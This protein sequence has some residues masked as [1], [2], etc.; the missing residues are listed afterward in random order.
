MGREEERERERK[1]EREGG[2]ERGVK[3]ILIM[4][5]EFLKVMEVNEEVMRHDFEIF[6]PPG[7][8]G[9]AS[10]DQFNE[11]YSYMMDYDSGGSV[12]YIL[13]DEDVDPEETVLLRGVR[14]SKS[15]HNR[16][17]RRFYEGKGRSK[18]CVV[19][20]LIQEEVARLQVYEAA[21]ALMERISL[22]DNAEM[23]IPL[24]DM[25][26]D[27]VRPRVQVIGF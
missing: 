9:E 13:Y 2:R 14:L 19:D 21:Y 18:K 11:F 7:L 12:F 20:I 16:L 27:A 6:K 24:E 26:R 8:R 3:A 17:V 10:H 25:L 5:C 1:R 22:I 15:A 4:L 23:W